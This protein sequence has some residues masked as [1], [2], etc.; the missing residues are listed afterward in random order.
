[1]KQQAKKPKTN[2]G[3]DFD[4]FSHVI[5]E[6]KG[7]AEY[8]SLNKS[9]KYFVK[10]DIKNNIDMLFWKH[11]VDNVQDCLDCLRF[12]EKSLLQSKPV[13]DLDSDTLIQSV[14]TKLKL[15]ERNLLVKLLTHTNEDLNE[16]ILKLFPSL[17]AKSEHLLGAGKRKT[18]SDKID[19]SFI[20]DFMH[21]YCR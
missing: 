9:R 1:M 10:N 13:Q 6:G 14:M 4:S 21:G 5:T 8:S 17:R 20:S 12:V 11:K 18:R 7:R 3:I 19:L 2:S 16:D 15:S